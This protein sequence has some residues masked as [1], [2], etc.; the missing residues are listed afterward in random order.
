MKIPRPF[1]SSSRKL[2]ALSAV[3]G[4]VLAA[5]TAYA[6][7][8]WTVGLNG[9][10]SANGQGAGIQA[11][12]ISAISSPNAPTETDVLFPS[13]SYVTGT[14]GCT[15]CGEYVAAGTGVGDG[16]VTFKL[17]N[18]NPYP[19]T[20]TGFTLPAETANATTGSGT[21]DAV[22]YT[23]N[24]VGTAISG[25]AGSGAGVSSDVAWLYALQGGTNAVTLISGSRAG[26]TMQ[27]P[28]VIAGTAS[29]GGSNVTITVTLIDDAAMDLN[30]PLACA[31]GTSG[32]YFVMPN[33]TGI[34]ATA[35]GSSPT[36][37]SGSVT[38]GY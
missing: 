6:A 33:L 3:S 31:N 32:A 27:G 22:G 26:Q 34:A 16:D 4:A 25:C 38:T 7:T 11:L 21:A 19:V 10:S 18:P 20:V 15:S 14:S 9:G 28:I 35:G 8:N 1:K 2:K 36:A 24:T 30:S 13:A 5:G 17:T 12:T 29:N 23:S 37:N